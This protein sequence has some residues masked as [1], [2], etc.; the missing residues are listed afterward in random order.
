MGDDGWRRGFGLVLSVGFVRDG[1]G[2]MREDAGT[3]VRFVGQRRYDNSSSDVGGVDIEG[4]G[5]R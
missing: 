5:L 1:R 4:G 3:W 2:T